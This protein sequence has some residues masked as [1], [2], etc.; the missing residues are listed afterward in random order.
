MRPLSLFSNGV[1][2][3]ISIHAPLTR[4]DECESENATSAAAFQSTHLLRGATLPSRNNVPCLLNFNPRTSYE[5]R[6]SR[7]I[8]DIT[9]Q[10]FQS[11]HLLRGATRPADPH[12][13]IHYISIHAPLTRCDKAA[14][15]FQAAL[16]I[17]QSTHL[18]RGATTFLKHFHRLP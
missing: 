16:R 6:L 12:H 17:S 15:G 4:C 1:I 14:G 18:L 8:R 13:H 11:T 10:K 9:M 5:V 3:I 7:L 2:S